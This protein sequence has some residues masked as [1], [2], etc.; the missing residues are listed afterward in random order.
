MPKRLYTY[1]GFLGRSYRLRI[2]LYPDRSQ[3]HPD[4]WDYYSAKAER[5]SAERYSGIKRFRRIID[6]SQPD[7]LKI[8]L[9]ISSFAPNS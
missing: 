8:E 7:K 4:R 1:Q 6:L 2:M 5:R 9:I 3:E